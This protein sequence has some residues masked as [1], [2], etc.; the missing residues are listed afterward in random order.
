MKGSVYLS[1]IAY[2]LG[3]QADLRDLAT[4]IPGPIRAALAEK[5]LRSFRRSS[6]SPAE[7]AIRALK[8]T[9]ALH[10]SAAS[11]QPDLLVYCTCTIR[12]DFMSEFARLWSELGMARVPVHGVFMNGCSAIA[13][14]MEFARALLLSGTAS[15]ILLVCTDT[16]LTESQRLA[17]GDTAILSDGAA[18]CVITAR[19]EQP[20]GFEVVATSFQSDQRNLGLDPNHHYSKLLR[21]TSVAARAA[22]QRA[23]LDAALDTATFR[24][25]T[26]VNLHRD[27]LRFYTRF[28][29][30]GD[31]AL[32]TGTIADNAHV[33]GAD[34]LINL[35]ASRDVAHS[36]IDEPFLTLVL[37]PA[38]WGVWIVRPLA[39]LAEARP[40]LG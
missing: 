23:A 16:C 18:S 11:A 5:G 4:T 21:L 17:R 33:F 31:D 15:R 40:V 37:S 9:L 28:C 13:S 29:G 27:A 24:R 32:F 39:T 1:A 34:V 12:D 3:E 8:K 38:T 19:P 22:L 30:L 2:E 20:K 6:L 36:E 14:G 35:L 26:S 10:A 7:L 25:M